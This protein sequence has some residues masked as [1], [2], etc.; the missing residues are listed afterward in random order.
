MLRAFDDADHDF[1]E[2][3]AVHVSLSGL[4]QHSV[5]ALFAGSTQ[6]RAQPGQGWLSSATCVALDA[7][8]TL[9]R[10]E[11]KQRTRLFAHDECATSNN[12]E[13]QS[14]AAAQLRTTSAAPPRQRCSAATK[15]GAPGG[16][17]C[18]GCEQQHGHSCACCS[19][20]P[21]AG[22]RGLNNSRRHGALYSELAS[23]RGHLNIAH[24]ARAISRT[25]R[26][27]AAQTRCG[28]AG[29]A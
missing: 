13:A 3:E 14:R 21:V 27:G 26:E 6:Q 17:G 28:C 11:G 29:C 12:S 16:G 4:A 5:R 1:I 9:L 23:L 25:A 2:V 10:C 7:A 19:A 18:E 22:G 15:V 8:S 20:Q 24:T